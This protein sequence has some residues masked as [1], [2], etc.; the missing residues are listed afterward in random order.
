MN[1]AQRELVMIG[2]QAF[3]ELRRR[4]AMVPAVA[5][6]MTELPPVESISTNG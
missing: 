1:D 3:E 4:D 6:C 5:V 2:V